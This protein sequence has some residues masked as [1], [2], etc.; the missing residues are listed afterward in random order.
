[1]YQ[2]I[3]SL[4]VLTFPVVFF[5]SLDYAIAPLLLQNST[6]GNTTK[7][8]TNI[9]MNFRSQTTSFIASKVAIL[10]FLSGV[11]NTRLL[12]TSPIN[13]PTTWSEYKPRGRL[14]R[15]FIRLKV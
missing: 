11:N 3:L 12:H 1:M 14:V 13:D 15:V 6:K 9:I 2:V 5:Y 7:D 8:T 10:D 4:N